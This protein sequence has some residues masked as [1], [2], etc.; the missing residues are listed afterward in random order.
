V[1]LPSACC[2]FSSTEI[3]PRE[4]A[5]AVPLSA[6]DYP[7]ITYTTLTGT[8]QFTSLNVGGAGLAS[9]AT[10][11]VVFTNSTVALSVVGGA[12]VATNITYTFNG[13]E[14]ILDWPAGQGWLLQSNSVNVAN[15]SSWY[16]VTGATPPFTNTVNP[17]TPSAFF[18]LTQ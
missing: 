8:G 7:L 2:P 14:L 12:P 3:R 1:T 15:P 11:S 9:G 4:I 5:T 13:S 16:N 17:A 10:A 18:R 6:G